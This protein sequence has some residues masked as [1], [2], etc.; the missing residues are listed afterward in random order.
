MFRRR[1]KKGDSEQ[2]PSHEDVAQAMHGLATTFVETGAREGYELGWDGDSAQRLDGVCDAVLASRPDGGVLDAM[3]M[4]MGA[5]LGELIV[6]NTCG[7]WAYHQD[8]K[9][10]VVET[11]QQQLCFPHSKV[12]KRLTLGEEQQPSGSRTEVTCCC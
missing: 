1:A 4:S 7:R 2:V 5:F 6:R 12:A 11:H 9:T 3:V 8:Q 10:A